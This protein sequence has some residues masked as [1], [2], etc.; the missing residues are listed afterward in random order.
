MVPVGVDDNG[1]LAVPA[2]VHAAG[3]YRYGAWPGASSGS[4]VIAG[5]VDSAQQGLGAFRALWS[6]RPGMTISVDLAH[7]VHLQYRIVSRESF[8]KTGAPMAALFS[9][10]GAPRLTL[11]TCG[12]SFDQ[13]AL[14]Y[15]DNVVITAVPS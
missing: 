12:G 8:A 5:H 3:W 13:D 1:D 11:I 4:V 7:G 6:A 14:S 9:T 2:D 10:K 15:K